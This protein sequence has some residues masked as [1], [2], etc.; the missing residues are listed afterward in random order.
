MSEHPSFEALEGLR[1]SGKST[2]AP[3]LAVAR[4]AVLVPTVPV[5]Y[6]PLRLQVD[7]RG[8]VE[9]RMC[10][11][12]SALFTAAEEIR[13]HLAVGT[14]VVVESYFARCL[15]NHDALGAR[16]GVTLPSGLPQPTTY[17]LSCTEG[18]RQ[19]RLVRRAKPTTRWDALSEGVPD[20]ITAA[21]AQFPMRRIDTT[22]RDP[23]QV[24]RTILA[25]SRGGQLRADTGS[26][27]DAE[28][29]GSHPH[30][31]PPVPRRVG[32]AQAS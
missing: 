28:P 18:E 32:G 2:V 31:L 3:L 12:L 6:Q 14:P 4:G 9:A 1:G 15:A 30:L 21:Y 19:R 7:L 8:N 13:R 24:V 26:L 25:A 20:R 23:E 10:F 5:L 11:Y 22:D 29:L 17:F 27:V 16:L